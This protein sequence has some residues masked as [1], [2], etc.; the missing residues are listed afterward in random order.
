MYNVNCIFI[1]S[2]TRSWYYICTIYTIQ[3]KCV[4]SQYIIKFIRIK[5]DGVNGNHNQMSGKTADFGILE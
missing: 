3:T 2:R 5:Y 1:Y 4:Y